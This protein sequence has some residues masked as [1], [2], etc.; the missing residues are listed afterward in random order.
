MKIEQDFSD[1]VIVGPPGSGKST[2]AEGFATRNQWNLL[3][4][5]QILRSVALTPDHVL[6]KEILQH[7]QRGILIS[8]DLLFEI[9][10]TELDKQ[11]GEGNIVFDGVIRNKGQLFTF[12][13]LIQ[14]YKREYIPVIVLSTIAKCVDRLII[15]GR[16]DD[17][18]E[19]IIKRLG[20]FENETVP[21]IKELEKRKHIN[22]TNEEEF[23]VNK[24]I[25]DIEKYLGIAS[26]AVDQNE[27]LHL[28][29]LYERVHSAKN[30][31]ETAWRME[32]RQTMFK[33]FIK[34]HKGQNVLDLGCRDGTL[35]GELIKGKNITAIDIDGEA[36]RKYKIKYFQQKPLI[37]QQDLNHDIELP[38]QTQDIVIAGEI[39]EHLLMPDKFISEIYRVLRPGGIFIGSTP[40]ALKLDKRLHL[41]LGHDPKE[42]SDETHAQYYSRTSILKALQR[43]FHDVE[44]YSY[45]GNRM[46]KFFT[47]LA[48]DGFIW[49]CIK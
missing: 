36:L 11:N 35:T 25:A 32:I 38:D 7:L 34:Q 26:Y 48:A 33:K 30:Y 20:D 29:Q 23:G 1:I 17:Y 8:N 42:F 14:D 6:H 13:S 9:V 45:S 47:S 3:N 12:D 44:F 28:A 22:V 24:A 4:L 49:K 31:Y 39:I 18:D 40:N 27:Y 21:A 46:I 37:I 2:I 15:R 19:M 16:G 5:G 41:L 10:K 43:K